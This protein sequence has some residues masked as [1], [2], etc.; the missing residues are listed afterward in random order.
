M[1]QIHLQEVKTRV[2]WKEFLNLPWIIFEEDSCWVPPLLMEQR[3]LLNR[4][5]NPYFQHCKYKAWIIYRASK[6]SGRI[7]A[8]IDTSYNELY[9]ESTG[10]FGFFE[11]VNNQIIARDLFQTACEWLQQQG[12]NKVYGPINFSIGNECGVQINGFDYPPVVQMSYN[13]S[14]YQSL[15]ERAGFTGAHDLYAYL[16][17]D[18][19]IKE[20]RILPRLQ[21]IT[22]KTLRKEGLTIRTINMKNFHAEIQHINSLFNDFMNKNWGFVPSTMEEMLFIAKAMKPIV[23]PEMIFFAEMNGRVI[24]YSLSIPDINQ[25][26]AHI[27]GKLFPFG[28]FKLLYYKKK[29]NR[30]RLMLLGVVEEYRTKGF[31]ILFYYYTIVKG[32]ERGYKEAE[33]SWISEDNTVLI[34]IV[35]KIGAKRYKTYRMYEKKC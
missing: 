32:L 12:M 23:D 21:K 11:C 28:L 31:D 10:F 27:N 9:S 24:G 34:S 4:K 35:E 29:I 16:V 26:L 2:E 6:T 22:E 3:R 14:Y 30:I 1:A 25:A 19:L 7:L 18:K 15:Y 8:Y 20:G 13:P 33:L 17:N 5:K